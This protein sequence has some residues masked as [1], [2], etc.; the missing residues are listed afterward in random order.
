MFEKIFFIMVLLPEIIL[1]QSIKI[2]NANPSVNY[3]RLKR[4]D[5]MIN[6]YIKNDWIKGAITIIVKDGDILQCKGYGYADAAMKTPMKNDE[7]FRIA[8]QT[9]AIA[10]TGVMIPYEQGK[11]L[12]DEPVSDFIPDY[13][14]MT[15]LDKFNKED[16]TYTTVPA[17][18]A[19]TIRDLLTHTSGIDYPGIGSDEMKAIYAK[20]GIPAGFNTEKD[21]QSLLDVMKAL[22]KFP[23]AH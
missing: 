21:G 2:N 5:D 23:L 12:L 10:C 15:V 6:G 20:G 13:K 8:S 17:E 16:T 11:L 4:I 1:A 18:R 22:A 19:I 14:D 3:T 9:K 7:L